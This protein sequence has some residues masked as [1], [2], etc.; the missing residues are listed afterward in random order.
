MHRVLGKVGLVKDNTPSSILVCPVIN[1]FGGSCFAT[2]GSPLKRVACDSLIVF[3]HYVL[4]LLTRAI[5]V[6]FSIRSAAASNFLLASK[7]ASI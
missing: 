1:I 3:I 6:S 5:I 4:P 7:M 2:L